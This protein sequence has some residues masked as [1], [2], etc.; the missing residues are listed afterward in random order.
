VKDTSDVG[1]RTY[2]TIGLRVLS[3]IGGITFAEM[4]APL[5]NGLVLIYRDAR[6]P[7]AVPPAAGRRGARAHS[8]A[9]ES[10]VGLGSV[11][12]RAL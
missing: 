12:V 3:V 5:I 7:H 6:H 11:E 10:T 2:C 4:P 8:T 1:K 9:C